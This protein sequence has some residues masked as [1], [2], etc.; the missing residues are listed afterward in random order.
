M[1]KRRCPGVVVA[2]FDTQLMVLDAL[3]NRPCS[4]TDRSCA[5]AALAEIAANDRSAAGMTREQIEAAEEIGRRAQECL[6]R[7]AEPAP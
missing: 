3:V 6:R 4:C 7:L 1:M 2:I 5:Q